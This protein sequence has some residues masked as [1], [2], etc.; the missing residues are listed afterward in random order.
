MSRREA[1]THPVRADFFRSQSK[2][3]VLFR[4][5]KDRIAGFEFA[6]SG[7][8][9]VIF[10]KRSSFVITISQGILTPRQFAEQFESQKTI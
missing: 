3:S 1:H 4:D 10:E 9:G 2:K 6:T 7:Y 8:Q 5:E